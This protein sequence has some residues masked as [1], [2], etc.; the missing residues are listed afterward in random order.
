MSELIKKI[1]SS[2]AEG[3]GMVGVCM[4][5]RVFEPRSMIDRITGCWVYA[6]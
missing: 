2:I 1:T 5:L 6:V 4:P 3:R